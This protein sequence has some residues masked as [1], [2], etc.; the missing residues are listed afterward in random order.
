[1]RL[2]PDTIDALRGFATGALEPSAL[3]A[4]LVSAPDDETLSAAERSALL[5]LRMTAIECGEGAADLEELRQ[6]ILNLL[7]SSDTVVTGS[8][9]DAFFELRLL[10]TAHLEVTTGEPVPLLA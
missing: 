9:S 8:N 10:T 4:F 5:A 1:M 3:D 7:A 2:S 6:E